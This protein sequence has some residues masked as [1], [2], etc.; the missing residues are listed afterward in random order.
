MERKNS[1]DLGIFESMGKAVDESV[2]MAAA[3][4]DGKLTRKQFDEWYAKRSAQSMGLIVDLRQRTTRM[5]EPVASAFEQ[6]RQALR[7]AVPQAP[8]R[9]HHRRAAARASAKLSARRP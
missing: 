5:L 2:D 7:N 9:A 6:G 4:R 3:L 1:A 8:R